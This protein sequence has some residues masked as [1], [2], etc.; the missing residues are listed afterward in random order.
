MEILGDRKFVEIPGE[1]MHELP[2]LLVNT[3]P[4]LNRLDRVMSMAQELVESEQ[5][6]ADLPDNL[7]LPPAEYEALRSGRKMELAINLVEQ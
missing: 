1:R 3:A 7:T 5:M 2:P 6:L 4:D